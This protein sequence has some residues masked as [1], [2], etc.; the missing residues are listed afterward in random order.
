MLPNPH[1]LENFLQVMIT[2]NMSRAAE[3]MGITQPALSQSIKRLEQN[4]GQILFLRNK[5]GVIPTKAGEKL[6]ARGKY[7]LEEWSKLADEIGKDETEI[8]GKF[9]LGVHTAV[10]Q[11]T[12]EHFLP[13]LLIEYKNLEMRLFHDLSRKVT[14]DVVSFKLDFG[15][16]VN[17]YPHP[18]LVIRELM[19]DEV[20]FWQ[21][22]KSTPNTLLES[23]ACLLLMEPDLAQT[24]DLLKKMG[25]KKNP[26]KRTLTSSSLEV[27]AKLTAHG[28]GIGLLPAR[29][30]AAEGKKLE[31][32]DAK[33]PK[34]EDRICLVYRSDIQKSQAAKQI[35]SFIQEHLKG[36]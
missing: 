1:D 24:Q 30:A 10:A 31:L 33:W 4:L 18:D 32:V 17:P 11:Y 15:I 20:A 2:A 6:G 9:N 7:L 12:L 26:F 13:Q 36:Y 21:A 27:I 23:P 14:E 22:K 16:A 35:I 8:R 3:R 34:F 19:R 25:K 29:V 28:A 5:S